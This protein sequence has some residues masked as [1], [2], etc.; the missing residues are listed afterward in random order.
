MYGRLGYS[1]EKNIFY[2]ILAIL[3]D[4]NIIVEQVCTKEKNCFK[5]NF[6]L[7]SIRFSPDNSASKI[8][9]NITRKFRYWLYYFGVYF[10][11]PVNNSRRSSN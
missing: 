8:T 10:S 1:E 3:Y 4:N 5:S 7:Y 9:K 6:R 2:I 11:R